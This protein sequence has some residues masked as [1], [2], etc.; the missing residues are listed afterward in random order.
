M[1]EGHNYLHSHSMLERTLRFPKDTVL[2]DTRYGD[3]FGEAIL[4]PFRYKDHNYYKVNILAFVRKGGAFR[5]L[6]Y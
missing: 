2:I 5:N 1:S 6:M 4:K 3:L